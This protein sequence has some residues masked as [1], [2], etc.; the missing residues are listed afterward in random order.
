VGGLARGGA[1]CPAEH[2]VQRR[3]IVSGDETVFDGR[4]K[5][6]REEPEEEGAA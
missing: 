1:A 2:R 3:R 6:Q 5:H 4:R